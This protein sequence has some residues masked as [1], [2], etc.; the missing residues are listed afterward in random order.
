ME[1]RM[2]PERAILQLDGTWPIRSRSFLSLTRPH[3]KRSSKIVYRS[4]SLSSIL[5]IC[6]NPKSPSPTDWLLSRY[7]DQYL[8][9]GAPMT[10]WVS[11]VVCSVHPL[12]SMQT[13]HHTPLFISRTLRF[14]FFERLYHIRGYFSTIRVAYGFPFPSSSINLI[15][16]SRVG[17]LLF[18]RASI[19]N[20]RLSRRT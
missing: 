3:S 17:T 13:S 2:D 11:S 16:R 5:P 14:A 10:L 4:S 6:P 7:R 9:N 19:A 20:G 15:E 18:L 1:C 8:C 12:H